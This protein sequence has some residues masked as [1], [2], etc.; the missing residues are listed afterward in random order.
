MDQQR[1]HPALI[2]LDRVEK[3]FPDGLLALQDLSLTI[4]DNEFVAILGPSGC[5]KSTMLRMIAGL[6]DAPAAGRIE[7]PELRRADGAPVAFVFQEPTLM[8]WASVFDNVWL[9]MRLAGLSR[10]GCAP[11]VRAALQAMGLSEF[12]QAYPA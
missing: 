1:S 12:E 3:R 8:P 6:D 11:R 7:A 10:S 5:G 2:R 4:D 9:P